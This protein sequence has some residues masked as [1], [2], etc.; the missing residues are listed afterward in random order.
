MTIISRKYSYQ[1]N[2][3]NQ[4]HPSFARIKSFFLQNL[5]QIFLFSTETQAHY[6]SPNTSNYISDL[7]GTRYVIKSFTDLSTCRAALFRQPDAGWSGE[8]SWVCDTLQRGWGRVT[9]LFITF[10]NLLMIKCLMGFKLFGS[11]EI[12][13]MESVVS[14]PNTSSLSL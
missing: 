14:L 7:R 10:F 6:C 12:P 11:G 2:S 1:H 8:V 4:S 9:A 3:V 13:T 5:S